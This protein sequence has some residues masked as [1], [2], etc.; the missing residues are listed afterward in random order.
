M[1]FQVHHPRMGIIKCDTYEELHQL[2][3]GLFA[4]GVALAKE[5]A[6]GVA[7]QMLDAIE[8]QQEEYIRPKRVTPISKLTAAERREIM[9]KCWAEAGV[10]AQKWGISKFEARSV[11]SR[12]KKQR[13]T[14]RAAFGRM[15]RD[16]KIRS[17]R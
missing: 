8:E 17:I 2:N 13:L 6:D 3:N 5:L 14:P 11:L 4:G 16:G 10:Y 15:K 1:S 12:A 9:Q 7:E